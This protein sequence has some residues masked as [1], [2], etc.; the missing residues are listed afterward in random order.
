MTNG[1]TSV[2]ARLVNPLLCLAIALGLLYY[3]QS[4]LKPLALSALIAILLTSP[5]RYFEKQGFPR[6]ISALM[7]L[8]FAVVIFFLIFYVI[9]NAIVSFRDD[10]PQMKDNINASVQQMSDWAKPRLSVS[11]QKMQEIVKASAANIVPKT[12]YVVNQ[13]LTTVSSVVILGILIVIQTFLLL[14]YRGLIVNFFMQLFETKYQPLIAELFRQMRYVVRGYISALFIEMLIVAVANCA[15]MYA[16]GIKYAL[17]LGIIAAVLNIIPYLGIIMGI[18]LSALISLTTN[19]PMTVLWMS[20][21]LIVIHMLDTNVLMPNLVRSRVNINALATIV[22]VII[23]TTLWGVL[24]TFMAV[25]LLAIMKLVFEAV[26][27]WQPFAL[28]MGDDSDLT[29]VSRKAFRRVAS[30]IRPAKKT[31]TR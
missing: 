11:T 26:P 14:L 12:S 25:P 10:L 9:V 15:M 7:M 24:G 27:Q 28:L 30:R 29:S 8:V 16:L 4:V 6:A 13:A 1:S 17:L 20:I 18:G 23:G 2:Y 22:G 31:G 5:C 3:G 19:T 21:S